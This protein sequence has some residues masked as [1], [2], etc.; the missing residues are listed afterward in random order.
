MRG[1]PRGGRNMDRSETTPIDSTLRWVVVGFRVLGFAWMTGLVIATLVSDGGANRIIVWLALCL[2][3]V[4]SVAMVVALARDWPITSGPWLLADG[5]VAVFVLLAPG[6]AGSGDLF[7]GGYPLSYLVYVAYARP[8]LIAG[9]TVVTVLVAGQLVTDVIGARDL[10]PTNIV[11]D[12]AV[13]VVS[14]VVYGWAMYALRVRDGLR[15]AAEA[16]LE[17]ERTRR[18]LADER[19]EIAAHLHDSVLQTLAL[20]Q[21]DADDPD[22]VRALARSQDRE[23]R[24]YIDEIS[25]PYDSSLRS[26]L[27]TA[28]ADVEDRFGVQVEVVV[29]GDRPLD[30]DGRA[31]VSA[32]REAMRNAAR[33]AGVDVISVYAELSVSGAEV[34]VRDRGR[35]FDVD[36]IGPGHRGITGS[37]F[38]RMD[39]HGGRAMVRSEPG[40]GTE[41]ELVLGGAP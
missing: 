37:I 6:L 22:R 27:R 12:V 30:D 7:F 41:V 10:S 21:T 2:A 9:T 8:T 15:L 29:V 11:G 5:A 14:G 39:R 34:F 18:Q 40:K 28:G 36:A 32:A 38:D 33:Y 24:S 26:E 19:A 17:R 1:Y 35:G 3:A 31:L 13:W 16:A 25:S 20:L 23:L 4:A